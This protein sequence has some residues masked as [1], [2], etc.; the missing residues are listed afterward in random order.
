[1]KKA[2]ALVMALMIVLCMVPAMAEGTEKTVLKVYWSGV[3]TYPG[4]EYGDDPIS[5]F[6]EEQA[7]VDVQYSYATTSD[8]QE[9]YTMLAGG[10]IEDYDVVITNGKYIPQLIDEEYVAALDVIATE[11]NYE[12]FWTYLPNGLMAAHGQ[13]DHLYYFTTMYGD[14]V[15]LADSKAGLKAPANY[16]YNYD[17]FTT[18]LGWTD[19][20]YE[21]IKTL[22]DLEAAAKAAK[23]AG[24]TYPMVIAPN[25]L[26]GLLNNSIGWYMTVGA[27]F[28]APQYV[29]PQED[30]T[31]TFNYK[32]AEMKA[33]L[34]WLNDMYL[35]GYLSVDNFTWTGSANDQTVKQIVMAHD[36]AIIIGH[37]WGMSIHDLDGGTNTATYKGL[38]AAEGVAA[39]DVKVACLNSS[40]I[41][42]PF[43]WIIDASENK[44][45]ALKWL[46]NY[47]KPEFQVYALHGFEGQHIYLDEYGA[48]QFTQERL[49]D[50]NN[51]TA[52]DYVKKWGDYNNHTSSF[53]GRYGQVYYDLPNYTGLRSLDGQLVMSNRAG[54]AD[55]ELGKTHAFPFKTGALTVN[56]TDPDQAA[57][58]S[59]LHKV[60]AE[61]MP[62]MIFAADEAAFEAAY[63]TLCKNMEQ[64]GMG[65]M[66]EILTERYW[67]YADQLNEEINAKW[68]AAARANMGK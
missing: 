30:G 68:D 31:V 58:Y 50:K 45:A 60:L 40:N 28:G 20:D 66:E 32:S 54:D 52:V 23:D 18:K 38:P 48:K 57:L 36:Y 7:G 24:I 43:A 17:V 3:E 65:E 29:Y 49:D 12:D 2:L 62:T 46:T 21:A 44:L 19:E 26:T 67:K 53:R 55:C 51:L 4:W 9:L 33:A 15:L 64:T 56:F 39:E 61:A 22:A 25:T 16:T 63:E 14:D 11:N 59:N 8:H 41:G 1:M 27:S 47:Q 34:K 42:T 37:T 6:F 13:N 10:E 35:K 5:A